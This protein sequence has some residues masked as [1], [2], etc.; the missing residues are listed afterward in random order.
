MTSQAQIDACRANGRKSRGPVTA[1]GL[2]RSSM[3]ALKHGRRSKKRKFLED[4]SFTYETR[5]CKWMATEDAQT[6][7]A[8]YLV[9]RTASLACEEDRAKRS[10]LER[11]RTAIESSDDAEIEEIHALGKRL[12]HDPAGHRSLYGMAPAFDPGLKKTSGNG[13]VPD[14]NDPGALV[15]KLESSE[16]GC[17][18]LRSA[19]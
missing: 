3:N 7:M 19:W 11:L 2:A 12:F 18:F 1:Q 10:H 17:I 16:M 8:E 9:A 15:R 4:D 6:D 5:R 14:P 13:E